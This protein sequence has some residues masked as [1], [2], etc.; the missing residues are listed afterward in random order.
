MQIN[1]LIPFALN[2]IINVLVQ[3]INTINPFKWLNCALKMKLSNLKHVNC[4]NFICLCL[5]AWPQN[6][7]RDIQLDIFLFCRIYFCLPIV[8]WVFGI[9]WSISKLEWGNMHTLAASPI[10]GFIKKSNAVRCK[11]RSCID[12]KLLQQHHMYIKHAWHLNCV[13]ME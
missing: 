1:N 13:T 11:T 12:Y 7:H 4:K 6:F 5:L 3:V 9:F 8:K 10:S 2:I